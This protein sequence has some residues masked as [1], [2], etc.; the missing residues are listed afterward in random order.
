MVDIDPLWSGQ[1]T[2]G[3][4]G[5]RDE[6]LHYRILTRSLGIT[7]V[8]RGQA[9]AAEL[10]GHLLD[11]S[12]GGCS[13]AAPPGLGLRPGNACT[14]GFPVTYRDRMTVTPYP[15]MVVSV[16][17]NGLTAVVLR[18]RFRPRSF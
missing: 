15:A 18:L 1:E 9:A 12:A 3:R 7:V 8:L 13:L 11:L 2:Q 5:M 4:Q 6:R 16:E 10:P 14:V 17:P